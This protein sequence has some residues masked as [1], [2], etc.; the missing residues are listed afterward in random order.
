M[1]PHEVGLL[2][3]L[4][5]Q[6][7]RKKCLYYRRDR[8]KNLNTLSALGFTLGEMF[9]IVTALRPE[10]ALRLPWNNTNP[11]FPDELVCEFGTLIEGN[12]IYVKVSAVGLQD[13]ARGC[14][15]SF[16]FSEKPLA[17]PYK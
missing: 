15:I 14:V 1:A 3:E 2:L 7:R 12:E 9:A 10:D 11:D 16:H 13:G 4:V 5:R 6:A 17:Y 8:E